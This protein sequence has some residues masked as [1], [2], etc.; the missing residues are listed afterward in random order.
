M[1][2]LSQIAREYGLGIERQQNCFDC[3][4][5]L[6]KGLNT[7]PQA[8]DKIDGANNAGPFTPLPAIAGYAGESG[9]SARQPSS[10]SS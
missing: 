5:N 7:K 2:L 10:R 1:R 3:T 4:R 8:A 6:E 9:A